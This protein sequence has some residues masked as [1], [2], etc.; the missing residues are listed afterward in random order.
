ML[1]CDECGWTTEYK[2]NLI[3]HQKS[4]LN[5]FNCEHCKKKFKTEDD[6]KVH[7]KLKHENYC[8]ECDYK[9]MYEKRLKTHIKKV[10]Q[11]TSKD[12]ISYKKFKCKYCSK[13][14]KTEDEKQVHEKLKHDNSFPLSIMFFYSKI[15]KNTRKT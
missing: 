15:C 12:K 5:K 6:K 10:H 7:K 14:L 11:K 13:K 9:T 1:K 2:R 3:R 8:Q 4:H